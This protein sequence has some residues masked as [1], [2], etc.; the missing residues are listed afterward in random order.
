MQDVELLPFQ[1]IISK[2]NKTNK[3]LIQNSS[4]E[5]PIKRLV[6]GL[7]FMINVQ[8]LRDAICSEYEHYFK[9]IVLRIIQPSSSELMPK[10]F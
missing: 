10:I 1:M 3:K 9:S 5:K 2:I 6:V 8:T 7:N 4:Q